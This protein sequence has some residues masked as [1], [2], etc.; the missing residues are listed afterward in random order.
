[1][2]LIFPFFTKESIFSRSTAKWLFVGISKST[3]LRKNLLWEFN[4]FQWREKVVTHLSAKVIAWISSSPEEI[5]DR[6]QKYMN[7]MSWAGQRPD[8]S[9]LFSCK[10]ISAPAWSSKLGHVQHLSLFYSFF[11]VAALFISPAPSNKNPIYDRGL[12]NYHTAAAVMPVAFSLLA[13]ARIGLTSAVR[14]ARQKCGIFDTTLMSYPVYIR[15][16]QR[17]KRARSFKWQQCEVWSDGVQLGS[18]WQGSSKQCIVYYSLY[19]YC[20]YHCLL[21]LGVFQVNFPYL[22]PHRF[23][24]ISSV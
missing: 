7:L 15:W 3:A 22:N 20:Y 19:Y 9:L 12:Q 1:M 18:A 17:A 11:S 14:I 6:W 5:A 21:C 4:H 13:S 8:N 16:A 23:F 10:K 2:F 24:L